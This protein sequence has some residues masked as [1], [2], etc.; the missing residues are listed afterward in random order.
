MSSLEADLEIAAIVKMMGDHHF[1]VR[2]SYLID[3]VGCMPLQHLRA[4]PA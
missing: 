1:I 4:E 2:K 3:L